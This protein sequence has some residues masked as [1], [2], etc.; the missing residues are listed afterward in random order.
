M[1]IVKRKGRRTLRFVRMNG[2]GRNGILGHHGC[3]NTRIAQIEKCPSENSTR[4]VQ[5][6]ASASFFFGGTVSQTGD[7]RDCISK[8]RASVTP[9]LVD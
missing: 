3:D 5:F 6:L 4:D 8:T 2:N 7:S 9:P 1:T